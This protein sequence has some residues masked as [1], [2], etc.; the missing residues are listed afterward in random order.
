M[1]LERHTDTQQSRET[2]SHTHTRARAPSGLPPL[3]QSFS[4]AGGVP[5]SP[6]AARSR[7]RAAQSQRHRTSRRGR[8]RGR[9]VPYSIE[10]VPVPPFP[11][12]PAT[13]AGLGRAGLLQAGD[14]GGFRAGA[15]VRGAGGGLDFSRVLVWGKRR[16]E[17]ASPA[18][19]D[20]EEIFSTEEALP[21]SSWLKLGFGCGWVV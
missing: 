10:A 2:V 6:A 8:G 4:P 15:T 3:L 9:I 11:L 18:R 12:A 13:P 16:E 21:K 1:L 5:R 17:T 19:I 7:L 20:E 14:R